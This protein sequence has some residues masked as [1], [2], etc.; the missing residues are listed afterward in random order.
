MKDFIDFAEVLRDRNLPIAKWWRECTPRI[1]VVTDGLRFDPTNAFG[2]S[3]FVDTLRASTVHGMTPIVKTALR[4]PRAFLPGTS[5]LETA[6]DFDNFFLDDANNGVTIG[7]YDVVFLFGINRENNR[8]LNG[9]ELTAMKRFMQAGGGVFATGDHENLG[10]AQGL[11]LPR[12]NKMRFWALDETPNVQNTTRLSTNLPGDDVFEFEDQSDAFPQRLYPNYRTG[13]SLFDIL[14]GSNIRR[15]HPLLQI[16]ATGS[17]DVFPDHPH[18]GE[19][20][21]P[22]DLST[23][24]TV[25]GNEVPEW[26]AAAIRFPFFFGTPRPEAVA[27]TMSY[28]NGFTIQTDNGPFSKD[29][30]VP[31]AFMAI[32]AYNGH[33]ANVG[34]VVTDATWHHFVNVNI[35]GVG[36]NRN[37]LRNADGTDTADLQKIR[38]YFRNLATWLM[39]KNVRMCL[40]WPLF[41]YELLKYPLLEELHLPPLKTASALDLRNIGA[42]VINSLQS[43]RPSFEVGEMLADALEESGAL[44][45]LDGLEKADSRVTHD[46]LRGTA[47][48]ALGAS[49]IAGVE[50]LRE[51]KEPKE[52]DVHKLF[53]RLG[54]QAARTGATQY[55]AHERAQLKQ[56]DERLM[57]LAAE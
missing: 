27:M 47:Y 55:L 3:Q 34:R 51:I 23:T 9:D 20:R 36:S 40:R 53:D 7:R 41:Y 44:E 5:T 25:D 52:L 38:H 35:D 16:G 8:P 32:S 43:H 22:E 56:L 39:P 46:I 19:C 17:V 11:E 37:G 54:T 4:R 26:P 10:A 14:L 30:L 12:V 48:A 24:F 42:A 21:V 31:R 57:K 29:A 2:L 28:G 15:P 50:Q 1:L 33:R 45:A 13:M 6:P 18:E 49:V